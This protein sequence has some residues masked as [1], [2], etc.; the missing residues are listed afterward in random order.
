M[1]L[2]HDP[3]SGISIAKAASLL[4][5]DSV[6]LFVMFF[7]L[8]TIKFLSSLHS[9]GVCHSGLDELSVRLDG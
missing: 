3:L 7:A 5:Q 9:T 1:L 4:P 2:K 6:E 8:E